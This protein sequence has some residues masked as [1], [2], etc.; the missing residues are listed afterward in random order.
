MV[1]HRLALR[2]GVHRFTTKGRYGNSEG[3]NLWIVMAD[4]PGIGAAV[5][6]L[7]GILKQFAAEHHEL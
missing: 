7:L 3:S 6:E 2:V 4:L 1:A 5:P